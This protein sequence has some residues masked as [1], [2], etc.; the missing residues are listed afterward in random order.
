MLTIQPPTDTEYGK[1]VSQVLGELGFRKGFRNPFP[2]TYFVDL[3]MPLGD[4]RAGLHQKWRYNLAKAER[5][6][7]EI[8]RDLS[9][10][11]LTRFMDLYSAMSR[12]KRFADSSAVG[13]LPAV[14]NAASIRAMPE[15]FLVRHRGADVAGAVVDTTGATAS[16]LHGAT[17]DAA[18]ALR[19]GYVLHWEIVRWLK[20]NTGC[21][22]YNLGTTEGAP[23]LRQ[24]K[25]GL[26]GR[27]GVVVDEPPSYSYA[28]RNRAL[29]VGGALERMRGLRATLFR[30][31]SSLAQ[32]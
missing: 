31:R 15:I 29:L 11:G 10:A 20:E 14:F 24:F 21:R 2:Q 1:Q 30:L 17:G 19:A 25:S 27:S 4:I 28:T 13:A 8:C 23:G 12:R 18:L 3:A 22:W 7:L 6:E 16:Y 9:P 32:R 26:V 5:N